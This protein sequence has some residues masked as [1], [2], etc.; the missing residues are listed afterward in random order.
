MLFDL[1][2]DQALLRETAVRFVEAERS[3]KLRDG[4]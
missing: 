3:T 2:D 4:R 1:T